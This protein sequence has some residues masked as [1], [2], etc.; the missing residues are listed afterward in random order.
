MGITWKRNPKTYERGRGTERK[1]KLVYTAN[2]SAVVDPDAIYEDGPFA[3]GGPYTCDGTTDYAC[4]CSKVSITEDPAKNTVYRVSYEFDTTSPDNKGQGSGSGSGNEGS[5]ADEEDPLKWAPRYAGR[6]EEHQV[7]MYKDKAGKAVMNS[8][9]KPF[10]QPVMEDKSRFAITVT[11]NEPFADVPKYVQYVDCVNSTTW[12]GHAPGIALLKSIAPTWQWER[13][14][15]GV[16]C[17]CEVS[18]FFVFDRDKWNPLKVV[19]QGCV[20]LEN[21]GE[22]NYKE[23][24]PR[25]KNGIPYSSPVFLNGGGGKLDE[26]AAKAGNVVY[27]EFQ[28]KDEKDFNELKIP[29]PGTIRP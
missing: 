27:L 9:G 2:C 23:V 7:V 18:Y 4:T 26:A 14:K 1:R 10:A 12:W 28:W 5:A 29:Y 3:I 15:K 20:Y 6:T 19:D 24:V 16:R 11:R 22:G 13:W 25:D 8:A 17:Y 21:V